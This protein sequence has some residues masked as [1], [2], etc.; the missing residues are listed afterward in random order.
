MQLF[1]NDNFWNLC[2]KHFMKNGEVDTHSMNLIFT[3]K[4]KF[5]DI[6]LLTVIICSRGRATMV[7]RSAPVRMVIFYH[8]WIVKMLK[9]VRFCINFLVEEC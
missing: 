2:T 4:F 3:V 5:L 7:M 1:Y 8:N 9:H 6:I